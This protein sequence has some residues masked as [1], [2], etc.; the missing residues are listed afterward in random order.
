V[1][2]KDLEE[3]YP[4]VRIAALGIVVLRRVRFEGRLTLVRPFL[5]LI[6]I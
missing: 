1:G 6:Q 2:Y 5:G 4:P 3:R